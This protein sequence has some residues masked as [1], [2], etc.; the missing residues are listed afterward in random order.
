MMLWALLALAWAAP[1]SQEDINAC[2]DAQDT[3]HMQGWLDYVSAFPT[4]ICAQAPA[5]EDARRCAEARAANELVPW[6]AYLTLYPRGFC[7]TEATEHLH[8]SGSPPSTIPAAAKEPVALTVAGGADTT[9]RAT[10]AYGALDEGTVDDVIV[11]LY[12][13]LAACGQGSM[14]FAI[15]ID[16]RGRVAEFQPIEM[17]TS[18]GSCVSRSLRKHARFPKSAGSTRATHRLDLPESTSP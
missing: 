11:A 15:T 12:D 6:Q 8:G 16:A 13:S 5:A 4:G 9:V 10:V 2:A 1:P 18:T 7:A 3:N 17:A 14:M